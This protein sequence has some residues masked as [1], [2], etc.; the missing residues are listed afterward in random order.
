[1]NWRPAPKLEVV[2]RLEEEPQARIVADTDE[3]EE[4]LRAW[5]KRPETRFRLLDVLLDQ[6]DQLSTAA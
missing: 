6:F 1:V 5:L 2:L 3:D 4:R